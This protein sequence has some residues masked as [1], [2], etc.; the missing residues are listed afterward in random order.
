MAAVGSNEVER[1]RKCGMKKS[2]VCGCYDVIEFRA[3]WG[4]VEGMNNDKMEPSLMAEIMAVA[5]SVTSRE[6]GFE[7]R[8]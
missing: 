6:L 7:S 3:T 4:L 8:V 5:C 1:G 2:C